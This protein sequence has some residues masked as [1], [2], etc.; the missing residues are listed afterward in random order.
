MYKTL[1]KWKEKL[2]DTGKGNKLIN[3]KLNS[4]KNLEVLSPYSDN[5][6]YKILNNKTFTCFEKCTDMVGHGGDIGF[7]HRY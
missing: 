5:V 7:F 1:D 6:F 3:Y 4:S 2:L